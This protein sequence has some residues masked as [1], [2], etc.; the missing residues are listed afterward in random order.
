M[1]PIDRKVRMLIET[2]LMAALVFAATVL[3][4]IPVPAAG[5]YVH[6][7]DAFVL[8]A[9]I[10]LGPLWGA[11]AAG[12]GSALADLLG[13]YAA[14]VPATLIIKGAVA[15]LAALLNRRPAGA[16]V[17][18]LRCIPAECAMIVGYL[19]YEALI[20]GYGAAALGE[21]GA[22]A[23]QGAAGVVFTTLLLPVLRTTVLRGKHEAEKK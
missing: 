20:L 4:K 3:V 15:L 11:A 2:S 10:A 21:V 23:V 19:A 7:G 5:G 6:P 12:V 9:G 14:Y 8:I 16:V 18:A 1:L 17:T 13:G 22:N